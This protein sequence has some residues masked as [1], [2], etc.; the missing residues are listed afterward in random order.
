MSRTDLASWMGS[1]DFDILRRLEN[2][3]NAELVLT[4]RTHTDLYCHL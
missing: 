2:A 4:R 1:M 3:G